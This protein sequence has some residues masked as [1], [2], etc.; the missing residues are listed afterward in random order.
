M[1]NKLKMSMI[2]ENA[3]AT[4]GKYFDDYVDQID[5]A[6]VNGDK[7]AKI[8]FGVTI[9]QDKAGKIIQKT[10]INFVKTRV[11]DDATVKYDPDQILFDFEDKK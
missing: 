11:K 3:L 10:E 5:E 2:K 6:Y 4:I 1:A 8:G 7:E 9:K